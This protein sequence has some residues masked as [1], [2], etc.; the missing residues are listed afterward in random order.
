MIESRKSELRSRVTKKSIEIPEQD[1]CKFKENRN[2]V[3]I[4][5]GEGNGS[6]TQLPFG[7]KKAQNAQTL[8]YSGSQQQL[9]G[10][11]PPEININIRIMPY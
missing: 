1:F 9:N 7:I 8:K 2:R 6:Q 5:M 11:Y 3:S 10:G 4:E